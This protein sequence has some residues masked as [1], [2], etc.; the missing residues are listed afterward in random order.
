MV[1]ARCSRSEN[2]V[3]KGILVN[4]GTSVNV[5]ISVEC[6]TLIRAARINYFDM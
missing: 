1:G 5:D 2:E 4:V 6:A 3:V